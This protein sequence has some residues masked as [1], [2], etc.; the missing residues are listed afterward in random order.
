MSHVR[1]YCSPETIHGILGL[2][3]A[4]T[5]ALGVVLLLHLPWSPNPLLLAWLL[6]INVSTFAYFG[7]DKRQA[8]T[9]GARVPE[10]VL[11]GLALTGGTLGALA[12]MRLFRHKTVK[13]SFR[14]LFG[15]IVVV[16]GIL[17]VW[18]V[19][20]SFLNTFLG[21]LI[22]VLVGM[23]FGVFLAWWAYRRLGR[24]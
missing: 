11:L 23:A 20:T 1:Q 21:W 13:R 9:G 10:V 15:V 22:P 8:V 24:R 16:Q 7:Y 6:G 18:W 2:T 5:I 3:V 19:L 17:L 14:L 4:L 12:A